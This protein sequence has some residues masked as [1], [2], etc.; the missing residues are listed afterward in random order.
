M[1]ATTLKRALSVEGADDAPVSVKRICIRGLPRPAAYARHQQ[2]VSP[3]SHP[4]TGPSLD[5][6]NV[7]VSSPQSGPLPASLPIDIS[8]R[9]VATTPRSSDSSLP[10][11]SSLKLAGAIEDESQQ[12]TIAGPS[13][14]N[15]QDT[16]PSPLH[17]SPG[18]SNSAR[19]I[20]DAPQQTLSSAAT[21][22]LTT[23]LPSPPTSNPCALLQRRHKDVFNVVWGGCTRAYQNFGLEELFAVLGL[24]TKWDGNLGNFLRQH[25]ELFPVFHRVRDNLDPSEVCTHRELLFSPFTVTRYQACNLCS[26]IL[27][28]IG[29]HRRSYSDKV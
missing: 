5:E 29:F 22:S 16:A 25:R 20:D 26:F 1:I 17:S 14:S 2:I 18:E 15:P 12:G 9:Q 3:I 6:R 7:S 23:S 28:P 13:G 11:I 4:P 19:P 10:L 21:P 27:Q 8:Q 24:W